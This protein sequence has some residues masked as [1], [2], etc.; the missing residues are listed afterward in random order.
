MIKKFKNHPRIVKIKNKYLIKEKFSF[1]TV[2][3]KDAENVIK[4]IPG[5]KASVGDILLQILK[6]TRF[7]YQILT[8]CIN[9]AIN[10]GVFPDSLK[11]ASITPV[12]KKDESTD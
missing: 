5:N 10:K 4:S 6:Q 3:V 11:I 2:S 12:H 1:Q 9:D 7:T 8:N